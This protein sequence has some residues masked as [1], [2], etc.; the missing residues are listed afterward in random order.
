MKGLSFVISSFCALWEVW[1]HIDWY[2]LELN[3][4][5]VASVFNCFSLFF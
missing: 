5:V 1:F 2:L 4:V 3:I